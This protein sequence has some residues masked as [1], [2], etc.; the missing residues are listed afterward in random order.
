MN[1]RIL[2]L[3][4]PVVFLASG[5]AS[6]Q[7][8]DSSMIDW[9]NGA[10]PGMETDKAYDMLSDQKS[11]PVIVAVI[12]S[13]VE[14]DHEDLKGK[15]WVN[16]DE[17]PNNGIDDD[18]NGYIDDVN[19]W[20]FLGD[21][22][23][24]QLE[25][26]RIYARLDKKYANVSESEAKDK[27]E[28]ALYKEVKEK[29]DTEVKNAKANIEQYKGFSAQLPMFKEMIEKELGADYTQKDV[30]G[31]NAKGQ[32]AQ[33][34]QYAMPLK[35]GELAKQLD[36]AIKHFESSL[37]FHYNVNHDGRKSVGDNPDDFSDV[38]YGNNKVEG[39][40][41]MHGSH[42][43]GIIAAVRNNGL[44]GSGVCENAL[45]MAIRA[46]PNGD[47]RD[48][49][50][51]LAI[52]YAVDN[53]AQVVNMSFGKSYS[54]NQ[55][56]VYEAIKYAEEHDVLLVHAAGNDDAD[57]DV[58][59]NFPS[60]KFSFQKENFTNY[61]T[62]GASTRY[63]TIPVKKAK[64][65]E[66]KIEKL[67]KSISKATKD[68]KKAKLMSKKAKLEKN[69]HEFSLAAPFSNYGDSTVD[70][71]APGLEIYSTVP[72]QKF[73][74]SQGTSMAA[75]MVTGAAAMIKSYFPTLTM[76][77][78]KNVL[79]ESAQNYGENME[80]KPGSDREDGLVTFKSLSITG[81]VINLPAAVE[82]AKK[83]AA[84]KAS[85]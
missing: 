42:C 53:G 1:K 80:I 68:E 3:T 43:S 71:F 76:Q 21:S 72:D 26:T 35:T 70:V 49:D 67:N 52:R 17:I 74:E 41:A 40:D 4:L 20:S 29:V 16:K 77:E 12:D 11:V 63:F 82:L 51:A 46:I 38:I 39:P 32:M 6:A 44:G 75:P 78:V 64:K 30:D 23:D 8:R 13:G 10:K 27:K 61:L 18:K 73:L 7:L 69:Y 9:Y 60:N 81:G 56:E 33:L 62:I 28:Y 83:K 37:N 31:W 25:M 59:A 50:V 66:K 45:I 55:K 19:G 57:V 85:K 15:I 48:K 22:N 24:E 84:L 5:I 2:R 36:G 34:K 58:E 65:L 47:E 54:P 14:I 79:L